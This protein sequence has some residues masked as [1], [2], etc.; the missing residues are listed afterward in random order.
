MVDE[1]ELWRLLET[2]KNADPRKL[3][4]FACACCRSIWNV[5]PDTA[6]GKVEV[7]ERFADGKATEEELLRASENAG[8]ISNRMRLKID[9]SITNHRKANGEAREKKRV[10]RERLSAEQSAAKAA[11]QSATSNAHKAAQRVAS[12]VS[13]AAYCW[14]LAN[15]SCHNVE[16]RRR[17]G[18]KYRGLIHSIFQ[19][20]FNSVEINPEWLT[21]QNGT[22]RRV[23]QFIYDE[24]RFQDMP[25]LAD[26]LEEAGCN[27]KRILAHCRRKFTHY[28]G[29]FVVDAVL[30][31]PLRSDEEE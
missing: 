7:A 25:I 9:D 4:L 11:S 20:I 19:D 17:V 16:M 6:K 5:I 22:V 3:R 14:Q 28:R 23:A 13:Y 2:K 10:I 26:A 15:V 1:I 31:Q 30:N 12:M 24:H 27:D 18:G 8:R 29:C 21:W